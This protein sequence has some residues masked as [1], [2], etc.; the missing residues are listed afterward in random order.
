MKRFLQR[1]AAMLLI[2]LITCPIGTAQPTGETGCLR[3]NGPFLFAPDEEGV[4]ILSDGEVSYYPD[5]DPGQR[6][7]IAW[8][9]DITHIDADEMGLYASVTGPRGEAILLL[10][11]TGQTLR[12]WPLPEGTHVL[13]L[14]AMDDSIA[15]LVG[16][17]P[18]D[19]HVAPEGTI[20]L[21]DRANGL[22]TS[23]V[24]ETEEE[25]TAW[26]RCSF[27]TPLEGNRLYIS[28]YTDAVVELQPPK[29]EGCDMWGAPASAAASG[30][31]ADEV[32]LLSEETG[33]IS[34][35]DISKR[36]RTKLITIAEW[37]GQEGSL[38]PDMTGLRLAGDRLYTA[39]LAGNALWW[40]R[41]EP[42]RAPRRTLTVVAP[43]YFAEGPAEMRA[44]ALFQAMHSD[45]DLAVVT[46]HREKL[47][48][49]MMAGE[50]GLDM[51]TLVSD[52][53][54]ALDVDALYKAGVLYDLSSH[55]PIAENLKSWIDIRLPFGYDGGVH[56]IPSYDKISVNPWSVNAG[57]IEA[58]GA[59][60]PA[61]GWTLNELYALGT[62]VEAYNQ[63][64][65]RPIRLLSN[66]AND[67]VLIRQYIKNAIDPVQ[68]R[69]EVNTPAFEQLLVWWKK[70]LES[71]LIYD[72]RRF[73]Q[74]GN[75]EEPGQALFECAFLPYYA[76]GEGCYVYPPLTHEGGHSIAMRIGTALNARSEQLDLALDYLTCLSSVEAQTAD[77]LLTALPL[78]QDTSLYP[79]RNAPTKEMQALG[80]INARL[81]SAPHTQ[82]FVELCERSVAEAYTELDD[83]FFARFTD[84]LDGQL[85]V[86]QLLNEYQERADRMI[87]H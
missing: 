16:N 72:R 7:A 59:K 50:P 64:A 9:E 60:V 69:I 70:G 71:G 81:P 45:V 52:M 63:T 31:H 37:T 17:Q 84:F 28:N 12:E 86:E 2:T 49:S 15:L 83:W 26:Q 8:R 18:E 11:S 33:Q 27:F 54:M 22:L 21:L 1:A 77:E 61:K 76:L 3:L 67:P 23:I 13:Q 36:Q 66:H 25:N 53:P 68:G 5:A 40:V 39:D 32:Y 74:T 47:A 20:Y 48:V 51:L 43:R 57:L 58:L 82:M 41:L 10:D 56:A 80:Q 75:E 19:G 65:D 46:P 6:K 79:S 38:T 29:L 87:Y 85:P 42:S 78:L 34:R 73:F 4:Y 14:E 30:L 62:L 44:W 55:P 35:Y 24:F